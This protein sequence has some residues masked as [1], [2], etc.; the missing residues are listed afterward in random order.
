MYTGIQKNEICI[1]TD[2]VKTGYS[3]LQISL[4]QVIAIQ[5]LDW[6]CVRCS[7]TI[8]PIYRY[9]F[10]RFWLYPQFSVWISKNTV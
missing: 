8:Y 2:Q 4:N 6:I 10:I 3:K 7:F 1:F 5:K 9:P